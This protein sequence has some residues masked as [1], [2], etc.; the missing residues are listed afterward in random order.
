MSDETGEMIRQEAMRWVGTP[1]LHMGRV[2]GSGC[3]CA[4]F[5]AG[6]F[7]A[8]GLIKLGELEWY[9]PD[10]NLHR[11]EE[12][13]L[14]RLL[15][16]ADEAIGARSVGDIVM[17]KMGR[18]VAHGGI[19]LGGE[20]FAHSWRRSGGVVIDRMDNQFWQRHYHSAYRV[21]DGRAR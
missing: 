3:D 19:W 17:F 18:T 21:R 2:R 16:Y 10:W 13:Y 5:I 4:T 11:S 20:S 1:Y 7:E 14:N 15:K 6:V 8:V 9:A 12:L